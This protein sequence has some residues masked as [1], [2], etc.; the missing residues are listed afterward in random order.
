MAGTTPT[1]LFPYP[2]NADAVNVA[3]DIQNLATAVDTKMAALAA[4]VA[5][6]EAFDTAWTLYVPT[7]TQGVAVTK[8]AEFARYKQQGKTV[9]VEVSLACTS[10]GTAGS[11]VVIG[12]PPLAPVGYRLLGSGAIY[13]ASGGPMYHIGGVW[14]VS[15][16][17]AN[18]RVGGGFV[19]A[20][21]TATGGFTA[22]LASGDLVTMKLTYE[23]A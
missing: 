19:G 3:V 14:W 22:A 2:Q 8:T 6:E 15:A 12:L 5:V 4:R 10:A 9:H 23:T 20:A 13:D 21:G 7:L 16:T 11:A 17:T 1:Q 18:I